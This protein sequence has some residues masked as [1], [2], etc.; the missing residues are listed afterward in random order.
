[1]GYDVSVSEN[2]HLKLE[3]YYQDLF[4]IPIEDQPMSN[5]SMINSSDGIVNKFL[6]NEGTGKNY[7]LELT[8]ERFFA[9]KYYYMITGS[10]YDSKYTAKD[11]IERNG[12]F[13]ADYA[14][15]V[16]FGKEFTI[17]KSKN[18]T[19]GL[20]TKIAYMG[21]NRYTPVNLPASIL[22][23][24]DVR[25]T[26][27]PFSTKGE[28]VFT[29]NFSCYYSINKKRTTHEIKLEILNVINNDSKVNEY[30]NDRT[31]E[32]EYGVQLPILPTIIYQIQF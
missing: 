29:P 15:N 5:Y 30:Y 17:G 14:F 32:I 4:S 24:E 3:L 31:Q 21:G 22:K 26:D 10:V 25:F 19:L 6:V 20:S 9:K 13:A 7:G 16:L 18:K 23:G 11:G 12:R 27:K 28:A 8:L 2:T 1:M